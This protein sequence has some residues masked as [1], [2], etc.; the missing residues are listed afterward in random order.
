M[1]NAWR[2]LKASKILGHRTTTVEKGGLGQVFAKNKGKMD[3]SPQFT[4][5]TWIE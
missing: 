3:F 4:Y 2:K 1:A 5:P